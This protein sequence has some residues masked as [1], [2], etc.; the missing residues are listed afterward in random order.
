MDRKGL[1]IIIVTV[2]L[3]AGWHFFY[4]RPKQEEAF[5][6]WKADKE[7]FDAEQAKKKTETVN[8]PVPS[9]VPPGTP[10]VPAVVQPA[11]QEEKK[12]VSSEVGTV[13]YVFTNI[14]GG[15]S[16]VVLKEHL[17]EKKKGSPVTINEFG[18]YA[19]GALAEQPG[20]D[21]FVKL[22]WTMTTDDSAGV[23][24]FERTDAQRQ[25]KITKKFST[26]RKPD[27]N[28]KRR[29][30]LRSEYLVTLDVTF[31]N[32]GATPMMVPKSYLHLG[33]SSPVSENDTSLYQGFDYFR[34]GDTNFKTVDSFAAG[35]MLFWKHDAQPVFRDDRDIIR[36]GAVTSQ[37]FTTLITILGAD[38]RPE[39][40]QRAL[41]G[42]TAWAKHGV[43]T[44]DQWRASGHVLT[45]NAQLHQLDG[46]IGLPEFALTPGQSITRNYQIYAGPR[47]LR[48]LRLLEHEETGV[49]D[50]GSFLG[51]PTG[52]VSEILLNSMNGLF[53]LCGSYA[54]AIII[55]TIIVKAILWPLQS[56]ANKNMKRMGEL[57]PQIKALQE[58]HKADPVRFQKEMGAVWKK[59]G[60][61]PLSGCWPIFIQIPIFI[62]F[63]NML[64]KAVELRHHGF[65]WVNDL[66]APDTVGHI[67]GLPLNPLP[68]LM[69][70]TMVLQMKMSPQAGD[71]AQ[72]RIF[73]LM[74]LIF[75][76]ICYNFAS[77]LA[78][79]WTVQNIISIVQLVI[80][81][82]KNAATPQ[83][84]AAT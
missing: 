5:K 40:E 73:M 27:E 13:D 67:F 34:D 48:R 62:G 19:I 8:A 55:L 1:L 49:L 80:N 60:V 45:G 59:A 69:A 26:P 72:R 25:I 51:I 56:K 17:V 38:G 47:E 65:L 44:P 78:L 46:A 35:G 74:P 75:I 79:Y 21:A 3:V 71:P 82:G 50:Y 41:L 32:V 57:Q 37:Y 64:G 24:T 2:G 52:W 28:D 54:L 12:T 31:T 77:A 30:K 4:A 58:K 6:K 14:G 36:W 63:Y 76:F 23:V 68:L 42:N 66:A 39:D 29:V 43:I 15:I 20:D 11:V 84:A 83:P 61:N 10:A 81:R 7:L 9:P 22:P 70:L 16:R 18:T 33:G 53:F